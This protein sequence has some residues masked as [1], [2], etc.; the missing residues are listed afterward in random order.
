MRFKL[1][2]ITLLFVVISCKTERTSDSMKDNPKTHALGQNV[3]SNGKSFKIFEIK[4]SEYL[5]AAADLEYS[6]L[7]EKF[8]ND[9]KGYQSREWLGMNDCSWAI[10]KYQIEE[11]PLISRDGNQ[12]TLKIGDQHAQRIE[13][14]LENEIFYQFKHH[15]VDQDLFVIEEI[16][17]GS[18][19][20]SH[21]ISL[22]DK[23][24][25][26]IDGVVRPM[27]N[28]KQAFLIVCNNTIKSVGDLTMDELGYSWELAFK[29]NEVLDL[30]VPEKGKILLKLKQTESNNTIFKRV[31]LL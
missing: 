23:K 5:E 30:K 15:L 1:T 18:C 10:E 14:D 21:L 13:H 27:R 12:L 24:T 22:K 11:N 20:K 17:N 29:P 6:N 3:V 26:I 7:A 9:S 19:S 8:C 16:K 31:E 2:L 4:K 28:G 25:K